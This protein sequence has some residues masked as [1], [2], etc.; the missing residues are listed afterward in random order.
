MIVTLIALYAILRR[1]RK[2]A[3]LRKRW[4]EEGLEK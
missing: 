1:R 4:A 3:G 2:S